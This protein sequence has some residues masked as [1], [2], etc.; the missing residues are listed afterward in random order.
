MDWAQDFYQADLRRVI[1]DLTTEVEAEVTD[2]DRVLAKGW[3]LVALAKAGRKAPKL[4]PFGDGESFIVA[5]PDGALHE[6][7]L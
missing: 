2:W 7:R 5:G 3:D 6:D 1:R 4:V